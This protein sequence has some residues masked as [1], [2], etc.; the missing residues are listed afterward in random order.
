MRNV[1]ISRLVDEL[2]S[3]VICCGVEPN[4]SDCS[5]LLHVIPTYTDS[6]VSEADNIHMKDIGGLKVACC[7]GENLCVQ[8]VMNT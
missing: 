3:Y 4:D 1:T 2:E 7:L 6:D 8:S 5:K